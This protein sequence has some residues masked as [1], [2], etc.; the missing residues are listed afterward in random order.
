[1]SV[2]F[3]KFSELA[4]TT[5]LIAADVIPVVTTTGGNNSK[6]ITYGSFAQTVS[7]TLIGPFTTT[8][9]AVV[10]ASADK[11]N[12]TY[13]TVRSNSATWGIGSSIDGLT[14][15]RQISSISSPN[16]TTTVHALSI[17]S[18]Q[19]N[20]DI[21]LLSKGTGSTLAQI[22]DGN[23]TGGSKR[24]QYATDWQKLRNVNSQVA[25]GDYSVI[26]GGQ[27]NTSGTGTNTTV[28]GG[29]ENVA[30]GNSSTVA[31]G[32]ANK[33][34]SGASFVGGG[35]NNIASHDAAAIGGGFK[36]RAAG[37][38]STV[39]GG[40]SVSAVGN[41]STVGGGENNIADGTHS[42]IAGGQSN[43][44]NGKSNAHIIGSYITAI[45]ADYTYVNNLSTPGNISAGTYQG[46]QI[47]K[48]WVNFDGTGSTNTDATI[49][50]SFNVARVRRGSSVGLYTIVFSNSSIFANQYYIP[51][52]IVAAVDG[53]VITI[54][55][56]TNAT[57]PTLKTTLSCA[58]RVAYSQTETNSKEIGISFIGR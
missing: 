44:I 7:S 49:N 52:G 26:G 12:S 10:P 17:I 29:Y 9:T 58:I 42:T 25:S 43:N 41:Y 3:K 40:N 45:S 19:A 50:D 2:S 11:W 33:A 24:G 39:G 32:V 47:P 22:P 31:G 16:N 8:I 4:A 38:Y 1:M 5:T 36:N 56:A 6:Q 15:F 28:G 46:L 55:S 53:A 51:M 30:S 14:I 13:T 34:T 35:Q 54:D 37:Q 20:V 27:N 18:G 48:A 57:S 21:A 23:T